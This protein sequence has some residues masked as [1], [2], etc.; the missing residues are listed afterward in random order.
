MRE[1]L[2]GL[3]ATRFS[4]FGLELRDELDRVAM[5]VGLAIA[6]A[7]SLVMALSFL[8]LSILFGFW[9]YRIWVCAIVAVVFLGIGALTWLKVRQLMNAA[10]DPFP[11][12]SEEFANDRKLIEAAFTTP[13]RNSEAE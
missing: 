7:F 1:A 8:S 13:S 9:A 5:M 2:G 4:L 3:I 12:T 10:A 6:A 11:F